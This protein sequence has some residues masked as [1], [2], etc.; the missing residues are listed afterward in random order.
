[1][2]KHPFLCRLVVI[3]SHDKRGVSTGL[4]GL[5]REIDR[6]GCI[7][8]P[9]ARDHK[10]LKPFGRVNRQLD[11]MK[12]FGLVHRYVLSR[13][14]TR[15]E[16]LDTAFYLP[17]HQLVKDGTYFGANRPAGKRLQNAPTLVPVLSSVPRPV[18]V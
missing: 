4:T 1:M 2:R 3:R 7:V 16:H 11:D 12:P 18:L 9:G 13:R 10:R 17:F 5:S 6:R 14:T 8:A 15:H